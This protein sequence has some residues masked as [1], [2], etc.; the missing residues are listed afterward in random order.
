MY[1]SPTIATGCTMLR[2]FYHKFLPY[3]IRTNAPSSHNELL[4]NVPLDTDVL[5]HT[6]SFFNNQRDLAR[7]GAACQLFYRI[8]HDKKFQNVAW[9][10]RNYTQPQQCVAL[11]TKKP[12][13][14]NQS[15]H[16]LTLSNDEIIYKS[17]NKEI[18]MLNLKTRE[19]VKYFN[20]HTND[21]RCLAKLPNQQKLISADQ[22]NFYVWDIN[23]AR[24]IKHLRSNK[25]KVVC[26]TVISDKKIAY[27]IELE[28]EKCEIRILDITVDRYKKI[29]TTDHDVRHII[30]LS[31]DKIAIAKDGW[32]YILDI[33]NNMRQYLPGGHRDNITSLIKLSDS[34]LLSAADDNNLH[35]WNFKTGTCIRPFKG[36][37][38]PIKCVS[39]LSNN[40][41]I[42]A[43]YDDTC[44]VWNIATGECI[45][46][47]PTIGKDSYFNLR[48]D[49]YIESLAVMPDGK[50]VLGISD[51]QLYILPFALKKENLQLEDE[52]KTS[53]PLRH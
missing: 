13:K 2:K 10:P 15:T 11:R 42:S 48:N 45:T 31:E 6:F 20:M 9:P 53:I 27:A 49:V 19:T 4:S 5:L 30:A 16:I 1:N 37:T 14:N 50:I 18:C 3:A 43:S 7:V 25:G 41:F 22:H 44:R 35:L 46:C 38:A 28:E 24:C 39:Q 32:V 26:M 36:H 33:N 40:E 47:I 51:G 8:A 23:A 21:I 34:T 12:I 29:H 17:S 52:K